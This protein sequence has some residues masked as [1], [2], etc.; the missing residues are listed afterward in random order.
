M[1]LGENEIRQLLTY[2]VQS[3]YV[4]SSTQNQALNVRTAHRT[5]DRFAKQPANPTAVWRADKITC[6]Q[7]CPEMLLFRIFLL[8]TA[9]LFSKGTKRIDTLSDHSRHSPNPTH[10]DKIY[11]IA[12][13]IATKNPDVL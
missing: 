6:P 3:K 10:P 4:S 11:Y 12:D 7:T 5:D 13:S 8:G 1:T 9:V 2:L